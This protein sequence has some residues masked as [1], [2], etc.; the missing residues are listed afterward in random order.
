MNKQL[1]TQE[2]LSLYLD[3]SYCETAEPRLVGGVVMLPLEAVA[4]GMGRSVDHDREMGVAVM[5]ARYIYERKTL[6][7]RYF[8][9]DGKVEKSYFYHNGE[10]LDEAKAELFDGELYVP[11]GVFQKIGWEVSV[12]EQGNINLR[13]EESKE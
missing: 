2:Q 8:A 12:S 9:Q 3:G 1:F 6:T 10:F 13:L 11:V 7:V 5:F 4:A